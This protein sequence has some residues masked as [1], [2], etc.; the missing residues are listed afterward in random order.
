MSSINCVFPVDITNKNVRVVTSTNFISFM[1]SCMRPQNMIFI[2]I[3]SIVNWTTDMIFGHEEV[4]ET[5][6]SGDDRTQIIEKLE[7]LYW[8]LNITDFFLLKECVNV[9]N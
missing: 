8:N 5:L 7:F 9:I 4:I 3:E 6:F 2:Q 1:S